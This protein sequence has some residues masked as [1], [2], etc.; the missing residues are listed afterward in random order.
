MKD[1][2]VPLKHAAR[3]RYCGVR[4]VNLEAHMV[5]KH[6]AAGSA[7]DDSKLSPREKEIVKLAT[8][9]RLN[10]KQIATL[11]GSTRQSVRSLLTRARK[12]GAPVPARLP[13]SPSFSAIPIETLLAERQRF[14]EMRVWGIYGRIA[15]KLKL[16]ETT[17]RQR[18]WRHDIAQRE[19]A[20]L[21]RGGQAA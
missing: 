4:Y 20:R 12:K 19:A 21:A 9:D 7:G 8:E 18:M 6:G 10:V 14:V 17:V 3:C 16:N 5:R 2:Y 13:K 1:G 15:R 11:T